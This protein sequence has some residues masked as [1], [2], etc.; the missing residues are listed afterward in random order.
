MKYD[1]LIENGTLVDP[2]QGIHDPRDVAFAGG[3]VAEVGPDLPAGEAR[4]VIDAG[5]RYVTPGWIDVHVHVFPN[6]TH[7]G[8]EPDP[9]CLARGATT[10]VDA[11]SAGADIFPGFRKYVIEVTQTRI[12]AELNISSQGMITGKVGELALP[13]LADVEACRRMIEA[14]R[15]LLIGVK[16]RLTRNTIVGEAA[17]MEPLHRPARRPMPSACRS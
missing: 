10:V 8:I 13:D 17:G 12:L 7:Y 16:A 5:G 1:L 4:V 9:T 11:G 3:V 6:V 2:G 15:D 14:N